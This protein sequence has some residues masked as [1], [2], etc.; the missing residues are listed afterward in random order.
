MGLGSFLKNAYMNYTPTGV[1]MGQMFSDDPDRANN[2]FRD[3]NAQD[4]ANPYFNKITDEQLAR[5]RGLD[6]RQAFTAQ[7]SDV[8]GRQIGLLGALENSAYGRGPSIADTQMRQGLDAAI[9]QQQA[10][11]ASGRGNAAMAQRQASLNASGMAQ[12]MAGQAAIN[13]LQEQQ[14][15]QGMLGQMLSGVRGQDVGLAQ[16]NAQQQAQNR[17]MNDAAYQNA[18]A[19]ALNAQQLAQRGQLAY[20]DARTSRFGSITGSAAP[21]TGMDKLIGTVNA[22]AQAYAA[23]QGGGG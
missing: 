4:F 12:N 17:A 13:R 9:R 2:E 14:Q 23:T 19:N 16:F 1:V 18:L 21:R 20:Q 22:G 11:A 10:L 3:V 7:D 15:A 6:T 5:S 8:R